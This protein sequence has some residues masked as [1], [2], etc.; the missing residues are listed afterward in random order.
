[1]HT[2]PVIRFIEIY[3][4]ATIPRPVLEAVERLPA[5]ERFVIRLRL[6]FDVGVSLTYLAVGLAMG[7][8]P[9]DVYRLQ[10]RAL[11]RLR[12]VLGGDE[13]VRL[14]VTLGRWFGRDED[15]LPLAAA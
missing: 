8:F 15:P 1:M 7:R 11:D 12:G 5:E 6:G 3:D 10:R 9:A 14:K 13:H 4:P 2:S